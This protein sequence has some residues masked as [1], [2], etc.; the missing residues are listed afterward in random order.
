MN[1]SLLA[2]K[3]EKRPNIIFLFSDDQSYNTLGYTGNK[4]V[5]TPNLDKLAGDGVYFDRHYDTTAIC[6][7]ARASAMTGLYEYRSGCNF[8]HGPLVRDIWNRSYPIVLRKAGYRTCFAGKFGFAVTDE[9]GNSGY[10]GNEAM[11]MDSFD[12][13]KGWPG[14]GSYKTAEN[15]FIKEYA[16]KYPHCTRALGAVSGDFI[17]DSVKANKPF[18]LSVSFKAPHGPH[19]PDPI[20]DEVYADTVWEK[21]PNFGEEGAK[22]LPKQAKSGRQYMKLNRG[23]KPEKYQES[24]RKYQQQIYGVDYAVGMIR[25]ELEAQ[26]V[27]ENTIIIFSSDN[28]YSCGAHDLGG[29]VL[30]YEEASKVPMI[31]FDPRD[32]G[33]NKSSRSLAVTGNIDIMPTIL[34]YAGLDVP[35]DIDGK[36]LRPLMADPEGE[37]RDA[38]AIMNVWGNIPT[39]EMGVVSEDYK[40]LYWF[41]GAEGMKPAQ[42]LYNLKDDPYEMHNLVADAKYS[43]KLAEMQKL[44]DREIKRWQ[45]KCVQREEYPECGIML[46]RHVAWEEKMKVIPEKRLEL[47][48]DS[49]LG[50]EKKPKV[51]KKK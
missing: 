43:D 17:K 25:K 9:P 1:S 20:F 19:N 50:K 18:C 21:P 7:A 2:N 38:M 36:S 28:G 45:E 49:L 31:I 40:Y 48:R 15:E 30:P 11:P 24:M 6:M 8:T 27:A 32:K 10:G 16:E 37:V 39:Y 22:H 51:K 35:D 33:K 4:Q 46:D 41:F 26:G 44:Y 14:Q 12:V 5:K 3:Q 13:W 23:Y 47:Y 34:D 29:K 42:E